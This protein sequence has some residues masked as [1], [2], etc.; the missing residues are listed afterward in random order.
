MFASVGFEMACVLDFRHA[1]RLTGRTVVA[2]T[3]RTTDVRNMLAEWGLGGQLSGFGR[4]Y[5]SRSAQWLVV[6]VVREVEDV[7]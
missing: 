6:G 3:L 1:A 2:L 4:L 5:A 7:V